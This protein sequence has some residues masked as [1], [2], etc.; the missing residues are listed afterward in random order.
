MKK[1][2]ILTASSQLLFW[3]AAVSATGAFY[4]AMCCN[5][6]LVFISPL[7]VE[8]NFWGWILRLACHSNLMLGCFRLDPY[9]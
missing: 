4:I 7:R 1:F 2:I 3:A 8:R 9:F 5:Y 6:S